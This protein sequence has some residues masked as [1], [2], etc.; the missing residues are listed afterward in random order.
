MTETNGK[1][2]GALWRGEVE[3]R[4]ATL[5]A[6]ADRLGAPI[7]EA[8]QDKF[9]KEHVR[10]PLERAKQ[11]Q[12][13]PQSLAQWWT[14]ALVEEAWRLIRRAEESLVEMTPDPDIVSL[15][16]EATTA[17]ARAKLLLPDADPRVTAVR[18]ASS[19]NGPGGPDPVVLRSSV[20]NLLKAVNAESARQH[21]AQRALRNRLRI[22][23]MTLGLGALA[24]LV[25]GLVW[26][27]MP[28]DL[29]IAP[30]SLSGGTWLAVAVVAGAVGALFSAIP[31][32]ALNNAKAMSFETTAQQALLKVVIGAWSAPLGVLAVT[33]GLGAGAGAGTNAT[34][35]GFVMMSALFGAAQEAL[36]R[37]A[38]QKA[39]AT[40]PATT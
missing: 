11:V 25:V 19:P 27:S 39:D 12:K 38:D 30:P 40:T 16:Q 5:D 3:Q 13:Q 29:A 34:V 7:S 14:G 32:L 15:N 28:K 23:T 22:L 4:V 2:R 26:D 21:Q 17:L 10:E 37:F 8:I 6:E 24:L 18:D 31:S 36:T 33:A 20:V 9:F 35:A 1:Y